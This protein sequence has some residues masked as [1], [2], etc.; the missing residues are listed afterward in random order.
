MTHTITLDQSKYDQIK[1]GERFIFTKR[2]PIY[3]EGDS[4][5]ISLEGHREQLEFTIKRID[6]GKIFK[7]YCI[8]VL[9]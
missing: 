6:T 4:F 8:I 2:L 7:N 1:N 9:N 5:N 3:S